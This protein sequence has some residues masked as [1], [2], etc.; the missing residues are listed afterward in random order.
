MVEPPSRSTDVELATPDTPDERIPLLVSVEQRSAVGVL[1]V[2]DR[3]AFRLDR[4]FHAAL[5]SAV[6]PRRLGKVFVVDLER[7]EFSGRSAHSTL[8]ENS[9]AE[10]PDLPIEYAT[11]IYCQYRKISRI[12]E[13]K[14]IPKDVYT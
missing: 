8:L 1:A 11:L 10:L 14:L 9:R 2:A 12:S 5:G 3:D 7:G 4:D 6:G 13:I